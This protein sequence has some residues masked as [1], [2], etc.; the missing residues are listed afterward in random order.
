MVRPLGSGGAGGGQGGRRN[1]VARSLIAAAVVVVLV[2]GG[3][4]AYFAL[5][6]NNSSTTA[7]T[8][9][10][11][12]S[13]PTGNGGLGGGNG[14]TNGGGN[15]GLGGQNS[16]A[17]PAPTITGGSGKTVSDPIDALT[18]PVPSGWTGNSGSTSG[19]GTWPVLSIG[20]YTCPSAMASAAGSTAAAT[21][22]TR[23]GVN[24]TT[25]SGSGSGSTASSS[26]T[27]QSVATSS[28]ATLAKDNYVSLASHKVVSQ[29]AVTVA[30][31]SGYQVTW[32]V[33][34]TYSGPGGTVEGIAVPVPGE[35]GYFTLIDIGVDNDAQAPSLSSVNTQIISGITDSNAAGA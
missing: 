17:S 23:G 26:T 5:R 27:A 2:G 1:S 10:T 24:F 28:I 8:Q 35:S 18:I 21:T 20:P 3:L 6:G 14:G 22:C 29:G 33:V 9:P 4:G 25:V 19:Q 11:T 32:S 13:T 30:G 15:G 34:P 31:R 7:S 12:G 16:S